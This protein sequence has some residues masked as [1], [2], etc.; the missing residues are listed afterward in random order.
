MSIY[1]TITASTPFIEVNLK[2]TP[3]QISMLINGFNYIIPCQS[4]LKDHRVPIDDEH[5]TQAFS[6]L[7]CILNNCQFQKL[8]KKLGR[9]A[10]HGYKIV[11]SIQRL[12]CRRSDIVVRRTD[13]N[14]VFY[15]GKAVDFERKAEDYMLRTEAYE[16]ITNGRCPLADNSS[17]VQSLLNFLI[18][19]KGLIQMQAD[20]LSQKSDS[21]EV[22]H[23]HGLSKPHKPGT[24]LRPIVA[25]IHA[26]ATLA[27]K[28][29]NDLLA[30]IY[31]TVA[32]KYTFINNIDVIRKLEKHAVD[33]YLTSTTKF[34]TT[35]VENLYTM[36]PRIGALEALGR[37]C[38][39]NS[40][41]GKIGTFTIDHI[42]KMARL[43]LD[44]NCFAYNNKY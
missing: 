15:I 41:K 12:I 23:Y 11:R 32:H 1:T 29:L 42:M 27:S 2:V 9:R 5:A 10:Q 26:P 31:L 39:K 6:A 28:F 18:A 44:T 16:E 33:G 34:I 35:D 43:I 40:K 13:K 3:A 25:S 17:A 37:F 36:I 19:K 24:P 14:K 22:G 21:L 8:S 38:S 30:P 7:E 4:C 20:R